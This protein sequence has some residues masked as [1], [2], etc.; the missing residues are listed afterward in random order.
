M[1]KYSSKKVRSKKSRKRLNKKKGCGKKV[2]R[3]WCTT[4]QRT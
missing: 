4:K 3:R 1:P 2:K